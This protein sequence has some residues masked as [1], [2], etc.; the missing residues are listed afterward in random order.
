MKKPKRYL[1]ASIVLFF[2]I[3][4]FLACENNS[5]NNCDFYS[6]PSNYSDVSRFPVL[7]PYEL[8]TAYCCA[9]W[10]IGRTSKK[11]NVFDIEDDIDIDSLGV[12]KNFIFI[13]DSKQKYISLNTADSTKLCYKSSEEFYDLHKVKLYE[14]ESAYYYYQ[15]RGVP[16]WVRKKKQSTIN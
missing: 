8:N 16:P 11:W 2:S 6:K 4:L 7:E 10:F 12:K 5:C 13:Y 14:I 15:K 9:E 3:S 1:N